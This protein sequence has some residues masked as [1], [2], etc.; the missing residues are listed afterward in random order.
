MRY[1]LD[2]NVFIGAM[3]GLAPIR[4]RLQVTPLSDIALSVIVLGELELGVEKSAYRDKNAAKLSAI[5]EN[6]EVYPLD[7]QVSRIYAQIRARLEGKGVTIGAN[8]YWIAAQAL[9]LD[10]VLV[11]D[12]EA[13][14]SRVPDLRIESWLRG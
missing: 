10:R 9:V 1:L 2:T 4:Q 7:A 8:D 5:L 3:K 11:T 13:E 14:F 6:I 12:N